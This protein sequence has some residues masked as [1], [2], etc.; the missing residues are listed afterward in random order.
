MFFR[1]LL[2]FTLIPLIELT[3]LIQIGKATSVSTTIGLILL[4]G[5]IGAALA[6]REGR[7]AVTQLRQDMAAGKPPAAAAVDG[8]L[9][10]V[11]GAV[12]L[13]PG[14]LTDVFGFSLLIPQ[15]R[16]WMRT[17]LVEYF[18]RNVR[19]QTFGPGGFAASTQPP[20]E[21]KVNQHP[22]VIDVEFERVD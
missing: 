1:L 8:I 18:K 5:L 12:L 22:D 10:L 6:R 19:V 13:T 7:R 4:T 16:R 21:P 15:V 20:P 3:L 14:L 9:I 2:L 11:A 17:R